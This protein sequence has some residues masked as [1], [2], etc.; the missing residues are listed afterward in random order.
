M[1]WKA[2][3]RRKTK[4]VYADALAASEDD[5]ADADLIAQGV[6][7][8]LDALDA[9]HTEAGTLPAIVDAAEFLAQKITP[10]RELVHGILHQG[11]KMALGGGSKT[12]KTWTLLDLAVAVA[13]GEPWLS[14]KTAKGKVLFANFEI[15]AFSFQQRLHAVA[16]EKR[17]T[18]TKGM[19]D[20]W[21]LRGQAASY[22]LHL[23]RVSE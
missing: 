12:F 20:V 9:E 11:S 3:R 8:T 1:I 4:A 19:I 7:A 5:A 2:Y 10:P 22:H 13:A 16:K 15:Q 23:P 21:N 17:V 18:V 14:F 6:R